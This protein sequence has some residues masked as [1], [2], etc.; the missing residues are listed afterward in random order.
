MAETKVGRVFPMIIWPEFRMEYRDDY[1]KDAPHFTI[2]TYIAPNVIL[3][4]KQQVDLCFW[5]LQV[6]YLFV[7][8]LMMEDEINYCLLFR[9]S[10]LISEVR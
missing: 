5:P 2:L 8:K 1:Q 10:D 3:T 4:N 6:G 7:A 9:N